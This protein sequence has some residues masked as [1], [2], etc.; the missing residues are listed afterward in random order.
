MNVLVKIT[1]KAGKLKT[2]EYV[3]NKSEFE[4]AKEIYDKGL[5]FKIKFTSVDGME[6][7]NFPSL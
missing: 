7:T 3:V 5:D 1:D 2:R 6:V 4:E